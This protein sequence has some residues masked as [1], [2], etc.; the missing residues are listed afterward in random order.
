L[1]VS[2]PLKAQEGFAVL[3]RILLDDG[4]VKDMAHLRKWRRAVEQVETKGLLTAIGISVAGIL[5]LLWLGFKSKL[6]LG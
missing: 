4:F 1:D 3:R 5:G 6:G 2:D